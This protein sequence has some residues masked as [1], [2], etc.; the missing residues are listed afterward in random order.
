MEALAPG[1]NIIVEDID[2]GGYFCDPPSPAFERSRELYVEAGLRRGAD[3]F[4][5][6]RLW[7]L[8]H[9]AGLDNVQSA[10]VQPYGQAGDAKRMASLTFAAIADGVV[11]RGLATREEVTGISAELDAF[12]ARSDTTIS[13]PR[14][15]QAWATRP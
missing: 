13:M 3:P 5:G 4:I 10:L 8:L 2:M 14:I 1:G 11:A 6:R 7:R 9:E 12:T 15:F